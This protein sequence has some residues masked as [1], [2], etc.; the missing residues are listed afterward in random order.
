MNIGTYF[1]YNMTSY[2]V[3]THTSIGTPHK[4]MLLDHISL[5]PSHVVQGKWPGDEDKTM[6]CT[7]MTPP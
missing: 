2:N 7:L 6:S 5:I 4:A 1:D 3:C